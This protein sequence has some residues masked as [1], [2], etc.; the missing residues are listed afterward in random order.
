MRHFQRNRRGLRAGFTILEASIAITILA[1]VILSASTAVDRSSGAFRSSTAASDLDTMTRRALDRVSK[2]LATVVG[3]SLA[4]NSTL[5]GQSVD[6]LDYRTNTGWN[7]DAVTTGVLNRISLQL[8]PAELDDGLDNDSDGLVDERILL[9][10]EDPGQPDERQVKRA[11][12]VAELLEGETA[13]GADDNGNG[14]VDESGFCIEIT[15][16]V[17]TLRLTLQR[18]DTTGQLLTST[19]ETSV[20]IRN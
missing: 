9:W 1:I 20:L 5:P 15:G 17:M 19:A 3:G 10:Q 2:D 11:S 14:L 18:V 13:N 4:P 6:T 16:N 12:F 8:D 7:G